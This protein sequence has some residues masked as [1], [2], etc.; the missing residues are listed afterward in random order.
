[1]TCIAC[2]ALTFAVS[3]P[4]LFLPN[5]RA[6]KRIHGSQSLRSFWLYGNS[7]AMF[8]E[9]SVEDLKFNCGRPQ[10]RRTIARLVF[11]KCEWLFRHPC[12]IPLQ[13]VMIFLDVTVEIYRCEIVEKN[14][15]ARAMLRCFRSA[16]ICSTNHWSY[17][18]RF[19][20]LEGPSFAS[21]DAYS[22]SSVRE[23][24]NRKS[25]S[26]ALRSLRNVVPLL[27]LLS[28]LRCNFLWVLHFPRIMR[29]CISREEAAGY[30]GRALPEYWGKPR[31][32]LCEE[33]GCFV[34]RR[35]ETLDSFSNTNPPARKWITSGESAHFAE[36]M[37][38]SVH[39][40]DQRREANMKKTWKMVSIWFPNAESSFFQFGIS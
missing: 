37:F 15:L 2:A 1:M 6:A 35:G 23:R 25:I 30:T 38:H 21:T 27:R 33:E 12:V 9:D 20:E 36:V 26:P 3:R 18:S 34:L 22:I 5:C 11:L 24:R 40:R 28:R 39:Q 10:L 32:E 17:I 7:S 31:R 29:A 4:S 13:R 14:P 19:D 8:D 16:W